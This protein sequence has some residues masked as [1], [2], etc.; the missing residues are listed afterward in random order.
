VAG[1]WITS[2][3]DAGRLL[4]GILTTSAF[5]IS[6]RNSGDH[7]WPLLGDRQGSSF[8]RSF[9]QAVIACRTAPRYFRVA[10]TK[11]S[12]AREILQAEIIVHHDLDILLGAQVPLRRLD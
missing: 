1:L 6:G 4:P 11:N 12:L 5:V 8:Q 7:K 2:H 9:H 3:D 10:A